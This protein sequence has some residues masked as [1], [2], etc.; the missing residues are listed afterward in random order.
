MLEG[1]ATGLGGLRRQL[2]G[3]VTDQEGLGSV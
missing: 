1:V 3:D 2:G